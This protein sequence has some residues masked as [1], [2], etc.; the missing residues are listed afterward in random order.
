MNK[1]S[2]N[3]FDLL[4]TIYEQTEVVRSL[5]PTLTIPAIAKLKCVSTE[6]VRKAIAE[7]E[8]TDPDFRESLQQ[9]KGTVNMKLIPVAQLPKIVEKFRRVEY[10]LEKRRSHAAQEK[11]A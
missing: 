3:Y 9:I 4:A 11:A 8:R 5:E 10:R 1:A 6:T 2:K 7:L